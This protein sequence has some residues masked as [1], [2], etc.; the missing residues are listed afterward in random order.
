MKKVTGGKSCY[1]REAK[2]GL[3][4]VKFGDPGSFGLGSVSCGIKSREES[5][6]VRW[7]SGHKLG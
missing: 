2:L 4:N 5:R 6:K 3:W 7:K 1:Q